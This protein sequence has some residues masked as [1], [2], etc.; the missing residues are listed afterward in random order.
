MEP[1]AEHADAIVVGARCSGSATAI[2]LA[3]AGRRVIALDR[4]KFPSDT[5]STHLLFA[6]GVSELRALGALDRVEETDAPRLP[7]ALMAAKD[8]EVSAGY[9]RTSEGID[10]G[11]S[12]RR[13]SLDAALVET[14]REA[15]VEVRERTK[16]TGLLRE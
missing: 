13:P 11:L 6:G 2:A 7:A 4:A 1:T 9:S 3:R 16:V 5:L 10:Y 14:A 8:M 15:G 12:V